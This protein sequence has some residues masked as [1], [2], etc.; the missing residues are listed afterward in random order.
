MKIFGHQLKKD[1]WIVVGALAA[2]AGAALAFEQL[3]GS[4]SGSR[5]QSQDYASLPAGG[6]ADQT[7]PS[8]AIIDALQQIAANTSQ[9]G[10]TG[11]PYAPIPSPFEPADLTPY[12]FPPVVPVA[13]AKEVP[14]VGLPPAPAREPSDYVI[15]T[16]TDFSAYPSGTLLAIEGGRAYAAPDVS[17]LG[18]GG[19]LLNRT[20]IGSL[21]DPLHPTEAIPTNGIFS[22]ITLPGQSRPTIFGLANR[23]SPQ[24]LREQGI[25][26]GARIAGESAAATAS[27]MAAATEDHISAIAARL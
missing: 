12:E 23:E 21:T 7:D 19:E 1:D 11:S 6:T 10:P 17:V 24:L 15:P 8:H 4:S 22:G 13:P 3:S 26:G 2:A 9:T 25:A 14:A 20:Y 27:R 5:S 18:P 16:G